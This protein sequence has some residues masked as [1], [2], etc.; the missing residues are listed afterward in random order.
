M[1]QS[2]NDIFVHESTMVAV[3]TELLLWSRIDEL[4]SGASVRS[5]AKSLNAEAGMERADALVSSTG[6]QGDRF[7]SPVYLRAMLPDIRV[8]QGPE[9]QLTRRR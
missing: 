6:S 8:Y 1:Q 7:L 3:E 9:S 5:C 2:N 4:M